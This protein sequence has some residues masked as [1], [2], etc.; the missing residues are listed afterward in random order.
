MNAP[1]LVVLIP[2]HSRLDLLARCLDAVRPWP[3]LVVDDSPLGIGALS[4]ETLRTRGDTGFGSAVNEGL[5]ELRSRGTQHA[6]ILNDDAVVRPGCI[7]AL[8]GAW[9][10][11]DGALG[12]ALVD[13]RGRVSRGIRVGWSG[14]VRAVGSRAPSSW[15]VDAISG[16]CMLVCTDERLDPAFS[17]G[18]EDLELC[19]RLRARSLAVRVV[20]D[21]IC[22]HAGGATV[23][24]RSRRAQRGAMAGHLRYL[25]GGWRQGVAV[26]LGLGQV[27]RERG[28][29]DRVLGIV[30]GCRDHWRS[31]QS[32]DG[33]SSSGAASTVRAARMASPRP[34]SSNTR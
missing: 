6:L 14:R 22:D 31:D 11:A 34:G 9:T 13:G 23:D 20:P 3:V 5:S 33:C 17:H 2:H 26:A 4:V 29:V 25:G 10:E 32:S 8:V 18:F 16:A 1:P 24:R 28:P 7:D 27:L 30:D 19:R 15:A 21:A 12:P